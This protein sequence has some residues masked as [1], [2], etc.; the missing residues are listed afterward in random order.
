MASFFRT[1]ATSMAQVKLLKM[2]ILSVDGTPAAAAMCFDY[3]STMYLYN[4]GYD[5]R[6]ARLS[7][8]QL[9]K[10]LDIKD[11]IQR[12]RKKYDLLKG[13]EG[14][15]HRMGGKEIPIHRCDLALSL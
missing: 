8:G 2:S 10:V 7:V 9:C 11:S 14:Y 12:G 5:D 13:D 1:L 4:N 6:F 3:R 15:K